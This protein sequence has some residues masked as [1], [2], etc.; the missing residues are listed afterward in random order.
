MIVGFEFSSFLIRARKDTIDVLEPPTSVPFPVQEG[1]AR[2]P[3]WFNPKG[4][5]DLACD[6][7]HIYSL[8]SGKHVSRSKV[9]T[10]D[11]SGRLTS[12]KQA[13]LSA[14]TER[15]THLHVYNR[16]EGAFAYEIQLPT[17]ARKIAV[18]DKYLYVLRHRPDGPHI[19]HYSFINE[20]TN[21]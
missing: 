16:E 3:N 2:L 15:S 11:L 13:E 17:A 10:L 12:T 4:T 6:S 20:K 7:S 1:Q 8:F 19:L 9:R 18:N 14:Q 21:R 5:L